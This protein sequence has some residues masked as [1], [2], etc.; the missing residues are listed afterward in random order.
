[1]IVELGVS[2]RV[3]DLVMRVVVP[4]AKNALIAQNL[5]YDI[6]SGLRQSTIALA[7]LTAR[8]G[9]DPQFGEAERAKVDRRRASD[10]APRRG[11]LLIPHGA[12]RRHE[13]PG[14]R[15]RSSHRTPHP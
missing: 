13:K 8:L 2:D 11:G 12:E 3:V 6:V 15:R 9:H 14:T 4:L 7:D 10:A 5:A 1:M